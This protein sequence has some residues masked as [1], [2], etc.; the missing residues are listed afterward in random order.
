MSYRYSQ[1]VIA[2][3]WHGRADAD[4]AERYHLHFIESVLPDLRRVDGFRA[5]YLLRRDQDGQVALQV[6]TLWESFDAITAFAGANVDAAVVEPEARA[7]LSD[8]D[9]TVTHYTVVEAALSAWS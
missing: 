7:A 6:V 5:G 2:R 9:R 4:G 8:Y 3:I 1:P